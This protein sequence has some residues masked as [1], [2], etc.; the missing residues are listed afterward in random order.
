MNRG[1]PSLEEIFAHFAEDPARHLALQGAV[2]SVRPFLAARLF[3]R[4]GAPLLVVTATSAEASSFS[5]ELRFFL[6]PAEKVLHFPSWEVLPFEHLSPSPEISAVRIAALDELLRAPAPVVVAPLEAVLQHL[7]P[8]G[9]FAGAGIE[10]RRG[11]TLV[12]PR[13]FRR[14]AEGGYRRAEQ[15][16]VP[17]E[18]SRRGGILDFFPPSLPSPVRVELFGEEIES[19]RLFD[20]G[21]QRNEGDLETVR[22]LPSR[23]ILLDGPALQTLKKHLPAPGD[24][25]GGDP[26]EEALRLPGL[27]HY[28]ALLSHSRQSLVDYFA[29]P[30]AVVISEYADLEGR[31]ESF[32]KE[33]RQEAERAILPGLYDPG[34]AYLDFAGWTASLRERPVL[35]LDSFGL[36]PAGTETVK[37][38]SSGGR[39]YVLSG[40]S[41]GSGDSPLESLARKLKEDQSRA[42]ILLV[43]R[44][45]EAHLACSLE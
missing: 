14:L 29:S 19:L 6:P 20:P 15:V 7:V 36:A 1:R 5:E 39:S 40:R 12:W 33:L 11:G 8:A 38:D 37:I 13:F 17:G 44:K 26:L 9:R 31:A 35:Y 32:R 27:E 24:G 34:R 28:Q 45:E 22:V 18:F 41:E 2:P 3:L 42:C 4:T 16:E 10:L 23:E 21:T 25:E 30:P 43:S